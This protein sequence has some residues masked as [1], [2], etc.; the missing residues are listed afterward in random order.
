M[1]TVFQKQGQSREIVPLPK[2]QVQAHTWVCG[3][4]QAPTGSGH[5]L[6]IVHLDAL[7]GA[8]NGSLHSCVVPFHSC[9]VV[10][11]HRHACNVHG[12]VSLMLLVQFVQRSLSAP[13]SGHHAVLQQ[14]GV[15]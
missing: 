13:K 6:Y 14:I 5:T 15:V 12:A 1:C 2:S 11:S 4:H 10:S 8:K 7:Y 9:N 3:W